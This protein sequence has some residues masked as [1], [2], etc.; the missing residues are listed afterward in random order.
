MLP[1]NFSSDIFKWR[2]F[3]TIN[4]FLISRPFRQEGYQIVSAVER[5]QSSLPSSPICNFFFISRQPQCPIKLGLVHYAISYWDS[6]HNNENWSYFLPARNQWLI[7]QYRFPYLMPMHTLGPAPNDRKL[8]AALR[9][10]DCNHLHCAAHQR[11]PISGLCRNVT[12]TIAHLAKL[13]FSRP[14]LNFSSTC[15]PLRTEVTG[16][17][18]PQLLVEMN[19]ERVS[20]YGRALCAF[21]SSQNRPSKHTFSIAYPPTIVSFMHVRVIAL[22]ISVLDMAWNWKKYKLGSQGVESQRFATNSV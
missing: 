18:S 1:I 21:F 2:W 3:N 19:R 6:I 22:E 13:F 15:S 12:R 5:E 9:F 11:W 16:V 8:M 10:S 7:V 20:D 17:L 4:H 14:F